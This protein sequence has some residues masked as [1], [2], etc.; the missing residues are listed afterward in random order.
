MLTL[1][2]SKLCQFSRSVGQTYEVCGATSFTRVP[3][4]QVS[5]SHFLSC[6]K[7]GRQLLQKLLNPL[8][9]DDEFM[10]HFPKLPAHRHYTHLL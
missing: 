4:F 7:V 3:V 8:D 9:A 2:L 5:F 1:E 10:S 6:K